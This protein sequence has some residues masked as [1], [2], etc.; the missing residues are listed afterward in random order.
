MITEIVTSLRLTNPLQF[1]AIVV[2]CMLFGS[3]STVGTILGVG[4][5]LGILSHLRES[6]K[7]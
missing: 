2:V 4:T 1:A 6:K 5:K 3:P 7:N